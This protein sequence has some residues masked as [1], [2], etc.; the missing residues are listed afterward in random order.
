M[1]IIKVDWCLTCKVKSKSVMCNKCKTAYRLDLLRRGKAS[2]HYTRFKSKAKHKRQNV[3]YLISHKHH[4][5]D[6][7]W[8]PE[9][10]KGSLASERTYHNYVSA[11][12]FLRKVIL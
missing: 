2:K 6:S 9:P 4:N 3:F 1:T 11:K 10:R 12:V 8:I 5:F 7:V